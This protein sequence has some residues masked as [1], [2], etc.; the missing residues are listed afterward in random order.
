MYTA[1][2][3]NS[4]PS[5]CFLDPRDPDYLDLPEEEEPNNEDIEPDID[6]DQEYIDQ[7]MA[8]YMMTN[9]ETLINERY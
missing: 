7:D 1:K 6:L 2:Q 3:R 4:L 9:Y 5:R 8:D